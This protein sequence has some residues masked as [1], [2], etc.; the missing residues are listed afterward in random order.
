MLVQDP[1]K[2]RADLSERRKPSFR[3][4]LGAGA[5]QNV[6]ATSRGNPLSET[7]AAELGH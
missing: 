4:A 6:Q 7:D 1:P 2:A 5:E 3:V